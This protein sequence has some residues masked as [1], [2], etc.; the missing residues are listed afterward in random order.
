MLL[1]PHPAYTLAKL[2]A[3][4]NSGHTER[5]QLH[6]SV[7]AQRPWQATAWQPMQELD[8]STLP[9]RATTLQPCRAGTWPRNVSYYS[10][11]SQSRNCHKAMQCMPSGPGSGCSSCS[12]RQEWRAEAGAAVLLLLLLL[13]CCRPR[14]GVL[15]V[16]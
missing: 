14:A 3:R 6:L 15:P 8:C 12:T 2:M 9:V 13:R 5:W 1:T 4:I 16:P 10:I 7:P 11:R